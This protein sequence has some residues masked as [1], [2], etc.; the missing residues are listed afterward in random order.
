MRKGVVS[1]IVTVVP[2]SGTDE[3]TGLA[4]RMTIII[5]GGTHSYEL[6]YTLDGTQ[7]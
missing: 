5:A 3:L 4:G 7:P 2:D 1:L 6:E